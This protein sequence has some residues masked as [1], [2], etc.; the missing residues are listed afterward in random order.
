MKKSTWLVAAALLSLAPMVSR[1][2]RAQEADTAKP[3]SKFTADSQSKAKKVY[4]QDCAICHGDAGNGQTDVG[5]AVNA[6]DWTKPETLGKQSDSELI[7]VVRKGKGSMPP[8]P[9]SRADDATLKALI[10]YV[11]TFGKGA[12]K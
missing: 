2:I 5:K 8:E 10:A 3:F 11:R 4:A 9:Q 7:D 1:G 6:A 12:A